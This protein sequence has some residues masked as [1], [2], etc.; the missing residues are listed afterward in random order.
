MLGYQLG[1]Q[2]DLFR[3]ILLHNPWKHKQLQA[4]NQSRH[5]KGGW[6]VRP[7]FKKNSRIFKPLKYIITDLEAIE[8]GGMFVPTLKIRGI[9]RWSKKEEIGGRNVRVSFKIPRNIQERKIGGWNVCSSFKMQGTC[10]WWKE[11]RIYRRL[12]WEIGGRNVRSFS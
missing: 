11:E 12:K 5:K 10:R 9:F 8:M 3:V 7:P 4:V 2:D 6:N 1:V